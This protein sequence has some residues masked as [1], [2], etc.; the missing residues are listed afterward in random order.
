MTI[1]KGYL[2]LLMFFTT[3][4]IILTLFHR[5]LYKIINL[6]YISFIT[7]WCGLY[8][9]FVNP[10][11][12]YYYLED[13]EYVFEGLERFVV[14]DVCMHILVFAFIFHMYHEFYCE[15]GWEGGMSILIIAIAII[16]VYIL[17][18]N[19]EKVY[20][21]PFKELFLVWLL[22]T[23]LYVLWVGWEVNV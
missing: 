17:L 3:W 11:R 19:I 7:L 9:S 14:I 22:G 13:K 10:R 6:E 18:V 23:L 5:R 1:L 12:Y 16:G 2:Y 8:M 15:A 4:N 20:R 21:L